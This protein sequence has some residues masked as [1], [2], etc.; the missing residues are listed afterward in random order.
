MTTARR[1]DKADT[2]G[3]FYLPD[4]T[5][6]DDMPPAIIQGVKLAGERGAG[7]TLI[8]LPL[9]P[10]ANRYWRRGKYGNMHISKIAETYRAHIDDY[11]QRAKIIAPLAGDVYLVAVVYRNH[12]ALDLNNCTKILYDAIQG[13]ILKNDNQI[14]YEYHIRDYDRARPRVELLAFEAA[15]ADDGKIGKRRKKRG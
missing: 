2:N 9:P 5:P 7:F 3:A 8:T 13:H 15:A 1:I 11:C 14:A 4:Q 10:S 12:A 6:F